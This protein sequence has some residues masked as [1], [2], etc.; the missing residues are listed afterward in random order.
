M[1]RPSLTTKDLNN[2]F[3]GLTYGFKNGENHGNM[4]GHA[5]NDVFDKDELAYLKQ[6]NLAFQP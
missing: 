1:Y 4:D 2:Y 6:T 3:Y 5:R